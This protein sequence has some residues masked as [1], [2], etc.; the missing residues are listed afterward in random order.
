VLLKGSC[1]LG[2]DMNGEEVYIRIP[3]NQIILETTT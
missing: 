3:R 2:E 1:M